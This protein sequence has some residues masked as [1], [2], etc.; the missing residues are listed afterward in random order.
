[1]LG[2]LKGKIKYQG[3]NYIIL[4]VHD[5]G[6][7]V[8]SNIAIEQYSNRAIELY[9]HH[10]IREDTS[11]LYGFTTQEELEFFELLLRVNGVGPKMARNIMA[12]NSIKNLKSAISKGDIKLLTAV[13]GV[14]KKIAGK[15]IVELKNKLG[16]ESNID[17]SDTQTEE[18]LEA[19]KQLDY[20]EQEIVPILAKIPA[21]LSTAQEKVRWI[22]KNIK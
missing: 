4:D 12:K 10:H 2:Y 21:K 22:L 5:V 1:M 6:Y 17:F 3:L 15:I 16:D 7:K 11:D 9:I 19:L 8:F 20:K 18:V 13:G 14:G